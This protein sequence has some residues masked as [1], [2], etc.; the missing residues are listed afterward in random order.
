MS[1]EPKHVHLPNM[2]NCIGCYTCPVNLSISGIRSHILQQSMLHPCCII[3]ALKAAKVP[4]F[5][6][7]FCLILTANVGQETLENV[8][9][10]QQF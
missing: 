2:L 1:S 7:S 4:T 9:H 8:F 3:I 6:S 10:E 5:L